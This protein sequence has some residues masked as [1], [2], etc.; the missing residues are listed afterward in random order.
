MSSSY[1]AN[2]YD[3]AFKPQRLQNWCETKHFKER[4]TAHV[5]HT[6]FIANDRGHLL[7]GVEKRGSAWP[8]F[9]G[10][11]D[12]PA[13]IPAHHVNPTARSAEGLRRLKVWGLDPQHTGKSQPQ[14]GSKNT[15]KDVGKRT[16]EDLQQD[17]AEAQASSQSRPA[18]G[19]ERA[20]SQNQDSQAAV[21]G[22]VAQPAE[23]KHSAKSTG[24]G[25]PLSQAE[26]KPALSAIKERP[27]TETGRVRPASTG[28]ETAGGQRAESSSRLNTEQDQ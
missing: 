17:S 23:D 28:S 22:S 3:S 18:T 4:P 26:E 7:P 2:Q 25:R 21:D 11:W 27:G 5:G 13:H 24:N 14:R 8:D 15:A 19:S 10:T 16:N 9:K 20:P 12:L 1:S 6:T